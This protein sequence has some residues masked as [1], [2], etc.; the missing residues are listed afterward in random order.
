MSL[1]YTYRRFIIVSILTLS[2]IGLYQSRHIAFEYELEAFF[3]ADDEEVLFMESYRE[4]LERDDDFLLIA[5]DREHASIYDSAFLNQLDAFTRACRALPFIKRAESITTL[6]EPIKTPFGYSSRKFVHLDQADRLLEDS[7]LIAQ[8]NRLY[9]NLVSANHRAVLVSMKSQPKLE[10]AEAEQLQE[11]LDSL[12]SAFG[13]SK[14]HSAGVAVTQSIFVKTIRAELFFYVGLSILLVSFILIGLFRTF[15]GIALPLISVILSLAFF[16]G[17]LAMSGQVFD[18][19]STMFPTLML[20]F[21]MSDVIHLQTKYIDE[22]EKGKSKQ[23]AM[24]VSLKEIGT[25]LLLTSV[26]TATGFLSLLFSSVPA[27]Q[28]FGVNAAAGVLIAYVVVVLFA[29][30]SLVNFNLR[31]LQQRKSQYAGW[32]RFSLSLYLQ[33]RKYPKRILISIIIV[34]IVALGGIRL[35]ST[36]NYL[37]GDL[38]VSSK[39]RQDYLFFENQFAGVRPLEIAILPAHGKQVLDADVMRQ[40]AMLEHYL[41]N[42]HGVGALQSPAKLASS[43]AKSEYHQFDQDAVYTLE[44]GVYQR[45]LPMLK[46]AGKSGMYKLWSDDGRMG[47][48]SGRIRDSGSDSLQLEFNQIRQWINQNID[49]DIV[50]FH[51][52]GSVLLVDRNHAYLRKNLFQG[53]AFAF[54]MVGIIFAL[55]FKDWRMVLVSILP[56]FIPMLVAAAALGFTGIELKAV[57]SVIFTVSFGIAVDDTIH[58]LTRYKLERSKGRSVDAA[59]R[60]TFLISVKAITITT[61]V[62]ITGFISLIFSA[63]TGTYYVGILVCITLASALLADIYLIPQLLY[64]INPGSRPKAGNQ[65]EG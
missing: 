17:Y 26:T 25:A 52:T 55:L 2:C 27:I 12:T 6:A 42:E 11:Q 47:R 48:I 9:K 20:I 60:H 44:E 54:V 40:A 14:N 24:R 3:P 18:I 22:L 31:Q 53:L 49:T 61:I 59:L 41:Q 35:I 30:A 45:I 46:R 51:L 50:D 34:L 13:F 1:I 64:M 39:L 5:I 62:L 57:T 21:G 19:M 15:W 28:R 32:K 36:N 43:L 29:S 10:Q 8:D 65:G 37:L 16:L 63:F 23:E 56:N 33:N 4:A 7:L 58:F 38:P